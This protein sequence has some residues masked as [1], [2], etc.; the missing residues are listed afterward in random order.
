MINDEAAKEFQEIYK[1]EFGEEISLEE[2]KEKGWRLIRLM[3]VLYK[4]VS[5]NGVNKTNEDQ[6]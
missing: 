3:R 6:K 1:K 5:D 4:E 2:A